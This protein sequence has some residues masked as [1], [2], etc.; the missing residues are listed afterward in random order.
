MAITSESGLTRMSLMKNT[1][2]LFRKTRKMVDLRSSMIYLLF[3]ILS[4][5]FSANRAYLFRTN[6]T[7]SALQMGIL[8][9]RIVFYREVRTK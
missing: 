6:R 4:K 2:D 1:R 8:L 5:I 7:K 3:K 9:I